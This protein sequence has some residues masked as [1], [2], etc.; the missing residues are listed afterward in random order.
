MLIIL[1]DD[2]VHNTVL[3]QVVRQ[4]HGAEDSALEVVDQAHES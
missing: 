4:S 3:E 2:E 1:C